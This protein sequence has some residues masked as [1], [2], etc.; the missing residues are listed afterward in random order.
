MI[1]GE[2]TNPALAGIDLSHPV[3]QRCWAWLESWK[4]GQPLGIDKMEGDL[5]FANLH[6]YDTKELSD[7]KWE[8]HK[9]TIDL[10]VVLSGG[11]LI[12]FLP[13]SELVQKGGYDAEKERWLYEPAASASQIHL[14]AGR[15]AVF[16]PGE[17]H[18]PQIRDAS[19]AGVIK[20]VFKINQALFSESG[21]GC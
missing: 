18:R 16:W 5:L 8:A 20:V 1:F 15:F 9:V 11:E 12:D 13:E 2:I 3:W 21:K 19:N 10:Q 17:P 7:C 14:T 4:P 6:E